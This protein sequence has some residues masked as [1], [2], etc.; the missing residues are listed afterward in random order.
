M[1]IFNMS[2]KKEIRVYMIECHANGF[3]FRKAENNGDYEAIKDAA[4][5]AGTVFSL[6]FFQEE[7]NDENLSL[8]NAFIYIE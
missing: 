6:E 3:D 1:T 4:E 2:T 5:K 8:L 7:V